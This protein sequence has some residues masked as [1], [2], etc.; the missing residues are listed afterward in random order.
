MEKNIIIILC[1]LELIFS[2]AFFD[3]M[4]QLVIHLPHEAILAGPVSFWWMYPIE[5]LLFNNYIC[6]SDIHIVYICIK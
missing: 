3:I 6:N 4:V 5:R 1:K 2:P